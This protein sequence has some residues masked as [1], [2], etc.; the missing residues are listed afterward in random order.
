MG[1]T[2]FGGGRGEQVLSVDYHLPPTPNNKSS[3]ECHPRPRKKSSVPAPPVLTCSGLQTQGPPRE[4]VGL[5]T[6]LYGL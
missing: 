6:P 5:A 1:G 3:F 2:L 4:A